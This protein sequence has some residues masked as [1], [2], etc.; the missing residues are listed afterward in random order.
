MNEL[1]R[2]FRDREYVFGTQVLMDD[3][4]TAE[5]FAQVGYDLATGN[6]D[7][8]FLRRFLDMGINCITSGSDFDYLRIGAV[9]NLK[10]LRNA[11]EKT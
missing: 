3:T 8:K 5:I 7:K 6:T 11:V 9:E 4:A 10:N 2:K 1:K